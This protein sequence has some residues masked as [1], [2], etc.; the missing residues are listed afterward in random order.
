MLLCGFMMAAVL[1]TSAQEPAPC[2]DQVRDHIR[3]ARR[4]RNSKVSV[5]E[6][7][8][9]EL[10]QEKVSAQALRDQSDPQ[11]VHPTISL[12]F[13]LLGMCLA[14]LTQAKAYRGIRFLKAAPPRLSMTRC[15]AQMITPPILSMRQ[16]AVTT[17]QVWT[18][19][20]GDDFRLPVRDFF[21]KI[22]QD[23][24]RCGPC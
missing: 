13:N 2:Y 17:E 20:R 15:M 16:T 9:S 23:P 19:T 14:N 21:W 7:R 8:H 3:E 22:L 18:S 4:S 1:S 12:H 5:T 11:V 6:V 10:H 24:L